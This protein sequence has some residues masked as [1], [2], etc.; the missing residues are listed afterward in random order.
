MLAVLVGGSQLLLVKAPHDKQ[1]CN[2]SK[3][4]QAGIGIEMV[5]RD[6]HDNPV[7]KFRHFAREGA[8]IETAIRGVDDA[9]MKYIAKH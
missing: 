9:L 6:E 7:A 3:L 8:Q 5:L 2:H 1:N 4:M